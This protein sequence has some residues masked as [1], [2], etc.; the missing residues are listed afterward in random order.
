V[1]LSL[2]A[3]FLLVTGLLA[4]EC[5]GCEERHGRTM[6]RFYQ[7]A[8]ALLAWMG[9]GLFFYETTA[10]K[11]G[12]AFVHGIINYFSYFTILSNILVASCLTFSLAPPRS[13]PAKFVARP[14]L[15]TA[16]AVYI[17]V[18][19]VVYL[20]LLR[21]LSPPGSTLFVANVILHYVV[22]VIYVL[23]WLVFVPKG[24]LRWK[25]ALIW[26]VFPLL[27]AVYTLIHG[28]LTG[29]YPYFFINVA[30]LGYPSVLMN[31]LFFM[32]GFAF[33]GS[34]LVVI[35]RLMGRKRVGSPHGV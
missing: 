21:K 8:A 34:V 28:S 32:V 31:C 10:Q 2:K 22:P 23:D 18:T 26:L 7:G 20:L 16:A 30:R 14:G 19:G 15:R 27:Y 9:L 3:L 4:W 17:I 13:A 24:T 11:T 33:L 25:Q 12:A 6:M 1:V 5:P 35:D 29:F